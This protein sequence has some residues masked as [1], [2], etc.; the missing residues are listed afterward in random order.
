MTKFK[1]PVRGEQGFEPRSLWLQHPVPSDQAQHGLSSLCSPLLSREQV[2]RRWDQPEL[3]GTGVGSKDGIRL[4]KCMGPC[5]R[6]KKT[7]SW[8]NSSLKKGMVEDGVWRHQDSTVA[9]TSCQSTEAHSG[10]LQCKLRQ[11]PEGSVTH[12][13]FLCPSLTSP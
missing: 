10:G 7:E 5:P 3:W 12:G 4:Q 2:S 6:V 11:G 8:G 9:S 1:K 13:C